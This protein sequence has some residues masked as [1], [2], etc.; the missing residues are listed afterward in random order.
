M[1]SLPVNATMD[2]IEEEL[3]FQEVLISSLDP[4]AADYNERLSDLEAIRTDLE[5]RLNTLRDTAPSS[6]TT[7]GESQEPSADMYNRTQTPNYLATVLNRDA[8]GYNAQNGNSG[9]NGHLPGPPR[10]LKRPY[11]PGLQ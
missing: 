3:E 7:Q 1:A 9:Y 8:S 10:G 4:E 2:E 11:P 6:Q 5:R